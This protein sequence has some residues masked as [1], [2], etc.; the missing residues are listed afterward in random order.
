MMATPFLA[1]IAEAATDTLAALPGSGLAWLDSARRAQLDVLLRD[2][3]PDTHNE[4]WKYTA[5]RALERHGFVQGDGHAATHPVDEDILA[6]PGVDGPR[7]VFVNGACRTD[8][9]HCEAL[10]DGL[11]IEPL[12]RALADNPEPLRFFLTRDW[13][14]SSDA[15]ARLNAAFA[16][17]GVVLRVAAGA[18]IG[19]P[20]HIVHVGAPADTP[21]AWHARS[22]IEV[23]EGATV[24]LVEHYT[25]SGDNAHL[26]TLVSDVVV[27]EHGT[28]DWVML[29][30]AAPKTT[31]IRRHSLHQDAHSSVRIHA[32]E[33]GGKLARN[34]IEADLRGD[35]AE[36]VTRGVFLPHARQH[37][38]THL[39]F[40]HVALNTRSDS[41]WRGVA[42][43]GGRGVFHGQI[44]VEPGADG[45][46]GALYNKN[47]L[48]SPNAEIDTQPVLEIYADE[49]KAEHGATVGQLDER[50]LFYLRSRG[51]A[52]DVARGL[53]TVAFC[54]VALDS[55]DNAALREHLKT[56]LVDVLPAGGEDS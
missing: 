52:E 22:I 26:G 45:S 42:D 55:L 27:R 51:I 37:L 31:L 24:H 54:H 34:D 29:Q 41:L 33:R 7:V 11:H 40:H 28:L 10:P 4:V 36:L 49:V 50:A 18:R 8:L 30:N 3:L 47:L 43:A 6:L 46:D 14:R 9:S 23:G 35:G 39:D 32:L 25:A 56:L 13:E 16:G 19:V 2:G 1:A 5:L 44:I 20:I 21:L 17:D 12:S 53:L 15:F 38:D 48:L